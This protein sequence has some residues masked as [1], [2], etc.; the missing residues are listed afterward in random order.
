M[1][2]EQFDRTLG[3]GWRPIADKS[4]CK[5]IAADLISEYS[6]TRL[7]IENVHD[8]RSLAWHEGQLRAAAGQTDK[9]LPLFALAHREKIDNNADVAWNLYVAATIAFLERDRDALDD[10][11]RKLSALPEPDFWASAVERT[12]EKYG[13]TP[14]WP[15][16]LNVVEAFQRCFEKTYEE[17][18]SRCNQGL[19]PAQN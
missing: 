7:G 4:G 3:E 14:V 5:L 15:S 8:R 9:A 13:F 12:V 16:N 6:S 18:Y 1:T 10:A 2:L 11:H 19:K 17:A